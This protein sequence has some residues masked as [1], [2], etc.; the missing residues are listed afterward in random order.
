MCVG[1]ISDRIRPEPAVGPA[2]RV[3]P[4]AG[5]MAGSD[6]TRWAGPSRLVLTCPAQRAGETPAVPGGEAGFS[7]IEVVAVML[8]IALL[9]GLA[10]AMM[11]GTGRAQLKAV[12]L[13]TAALLRRE[14]LGAVLTGGNRVVSLDGERRAFVGDGGHAVAIPRD[15]VVNIL[16]VDEQLSGRQTVVR[17]HPDGASSGTVLRLSRQGMEYEIRVNWYTG[18]VAVEP[19]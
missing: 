6:R 3:R 17:F 18:G 14:R 2:Q 5:P 13:E 12:A 4:P 15:V 10:V 11:P 16:G 7:L 9:S 8:I 19:R 1:R